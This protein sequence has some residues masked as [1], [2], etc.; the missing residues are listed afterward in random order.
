MR[1]S[2]IIICLLVTTVGSL[3][4]NP[5]TRGKGADA[6]I[7]W[8]STRSATPRDVGADLCGPTVHTGAHT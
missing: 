2:A 1:H 8:Y 6:A 4:G 3:T 7:E 5:A